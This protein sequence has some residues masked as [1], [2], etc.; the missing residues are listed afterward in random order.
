MPL[1]AEPFGPGTVNISDLAAAIRAVYG[2]ILI[3]P[4][5]TLK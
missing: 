5:A 4:S 3:P 1:P 2:G